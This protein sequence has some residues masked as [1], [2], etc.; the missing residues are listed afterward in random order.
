MT[1]EARPDAKPEGKTEAKTDAKTDT[2]V[3]AGTDGV[4]RVT[5][6]PP[7]F[8]PWAGKLAELYFSGTAASQS[9]AGSGSPTSSPSSCSAAGTW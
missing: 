1:D 9:R 2:K 3:L 8:P 5:A 6:L 7:H 4:S